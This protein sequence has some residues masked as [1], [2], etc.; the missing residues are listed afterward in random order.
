MGIIIIINS[1]RVVVRLKKITLIRLL[2]WCLAD[3]T[4]P[5]NISYSAVSK[6]SWMGAKNIEK[7]ARSPDAK[8]APPNVV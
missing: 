6:S 4:Y 3:S 5:I 7:L 1:W 2:T 8:S